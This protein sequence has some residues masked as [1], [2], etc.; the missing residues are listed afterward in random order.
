MTVEQAAHRYGMDKEN[1]IKNLNDA[2]K[3]K[4]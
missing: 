2:L 3:V 1:L 4:S